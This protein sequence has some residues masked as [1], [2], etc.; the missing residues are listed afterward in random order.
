MGCR[1]NEECGPG[2]TCC[3]FPII[4]DIANLCI[5]EAC[6]SEGCIPLFAR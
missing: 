1:S 4:G 3:T 2:N 6:R 5:P